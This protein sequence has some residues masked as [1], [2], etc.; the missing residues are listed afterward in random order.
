M[1]F[2][3]HDRV[4][5]INYWSHQ[6][7]QQQQ[8]QQQ[9]QQQQHQQQVQQQISCPTGVAV[10]PPVAPASREKLFVLT[11]KRWSSGC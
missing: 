6:Q 3:Y 9:L 7:Q 4:T 11:S 2:S 1:V 5:T 8:Q 10:S